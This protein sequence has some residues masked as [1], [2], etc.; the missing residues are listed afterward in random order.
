MGRAY[1]FTIMAYL[2]RIGLS[3]RKADANTKAPIVIEHKDGILV[4]GKTMVNVSS[5]DRDPIMKGRPYLITDYVE[6]DAEGSTT[7][8]WSEHKATN[9]LWGAWSDETKKDI[10]WPGGEL[11]N[12]RKLQAA[13]AVKPVDI[14]ILLTKLIHFNTPADAAAFDEMGKF[15]AYMMMKEFGMKPID[16]GKFIP[17]PNSEI[18][19][20]RGLSIRPYFVD[21]NPTPLT[22]YRTFLYS[23]QLKTRE[24]I[25]R[26][27]ADA[28]QTVIDSEGNEVGSPALIEAARLNRVAKMNEK[29]ANDPLS[30]KRAEL[31]APTAEELAL[32]Q[33]I[34]GYRE[35]M[36][37]FEA[38]RANL[39]TVELDAL[40]TT[41]AELKAATEQ[42]VALESGRQAALD[43][44]K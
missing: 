33:K 26:A 29:N 14:N 19:E 8:G 22:T 9:T 39:T 34:E 37:D 28:G 13:C 17:I 42:L 4:D 3:T 10:I 18:P 21:G 5:G 43:A 7:S 16:F 6:T 2:K 36:V 32:S 1:K 23:A 31:S 35:S 11:V 38:N 30:A 12:P 24:S 20:M 27:F 44:L 41:E 25:I 40:A 15:R